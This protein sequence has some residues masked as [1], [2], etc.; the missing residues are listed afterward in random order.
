LAKALNV[1]NSESVVFCGP[2]FKATRR[3]MTM[4]RYWTGNKSSQNGL[5]DIL[6]YDNSIVAYNNTVKDF[7]FTSK[8]SLKFVLG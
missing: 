2:F 5:G 4:N 1:R 7:M 8:V 6:S 3:T